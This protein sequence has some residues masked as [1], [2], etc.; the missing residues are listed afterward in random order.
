M[1]DVFFKIKAFSKLTGLSV[2]TLQYYDDIRLL[3]P[4]KKDSNGFRFYGTESFARVFIIRSLKDIGMTLDEIKK[5]L[6]GNPLSLTEFVGKE[7]R[8]KEEAIIHLQKQLVLLE[9]LEN[10]LSNSFL[11]QPEFVSLLSS[12][13]SMDDFFPD[14]ENTFCEKPKSELSDFSQFLLDLDYCRVHELKI[15]HELVQKCLSFWKDILNIW[16]D[17]QEKIIE[18]SENKYQDSDET[19]G[20]TGENYVYLKRIFDETNKID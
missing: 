9:N 6:L 7:I 3:I 2:R 10:N 13:I 16:G 11:N 14:T 5:Y 15:D 4:E 12:D 18:F 8:K 19:Y 20:M 17:Q 1:T